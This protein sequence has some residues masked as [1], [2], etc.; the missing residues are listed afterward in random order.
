[1]RSRMSLFFAG[2][3]RALS[4]EGRAAMLIGDMDISRL[5][6]YVQQVKAEKLWDREVYRNK[7]SKTGNKSGQQKDSCFKCGQ[8][9]HFM[10]ECPKNRQ[11]SGNLGNIAQFSSVAP[12]DRV[13]PIGDPSDPGESLSFLTPYVANKFEILPEKFCEPF[14]VST[15]VGQSILEEKV[16]RDCP[17]SIN[18]KNNMADLVEV[19]MVDFDVILNMDWLRACYASI[20]CRT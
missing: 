12:L 14:G 13:A 3:G 17:I 9:G 20:Y 8:E 11:G 15:L 1:M 7:K 18:H 16:Y 19:D 5:T 10:R 4:K 2:L 6:V